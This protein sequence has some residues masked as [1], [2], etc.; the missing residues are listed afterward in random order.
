MV[1]FVNIMQS[2]DVLIP[3]EL[4]QGIWEPEV[5]VDS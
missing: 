5:I 3:Y 4:E 2:E 1:P